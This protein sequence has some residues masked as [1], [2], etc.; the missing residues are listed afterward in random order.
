MYTINQK[1]TLSTTMSIE[2][3]D[4]ICSSS[5]LLSFGLLTL[6]PTLPM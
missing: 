5:N 6:G 3:T 2:R 4:P 1:I